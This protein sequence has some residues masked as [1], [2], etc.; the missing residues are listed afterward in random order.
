MPR[1]RTTRQSSG[2]WISCRVIDRS[3]S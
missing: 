3:D 1:R 2:R